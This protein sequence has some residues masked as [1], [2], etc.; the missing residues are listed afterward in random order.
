MACAS[1][2]DN[3]RPARSSHIQ[4]T[5]DSVGGGASKA[6]AITKNCAVRTTARNSRGSQGCSCSSRAS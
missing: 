6:L 5:R 4:R 1:C 3:R 2:S